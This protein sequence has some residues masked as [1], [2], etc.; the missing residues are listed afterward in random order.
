MKKIARALGILLLVAF[1]FS[2]CSKLFDEKKYNENTLADDYAKY[3]G[4]NGGS[5]S[6]SGGFGGG[7]GDNGGSSSINIEYTNEYDYTLEE[8]RAQ[9]EA[10]KEALKKLNYK[11][12]TYF[13]P[14]PTPPDEKQE[15]IIINEK[16]QQVFWKDD[17][18]IGGGIIYYYSPDKSRI[19]LGTSAANLFSACKKFYEIDMSG[20]DTRDVTTMES[21]FSFCESLLRVNMSSFNTSKVEKMTGMFYGCNRI[22]E[23]DFSSFNT[24]AVTS[25]SSMFMYCHSL[26]GLDLSNFNTSNVIYMDSMFESCKDHDFKELDLS[27][28]DT[29]KVISMEDMFSNCI[30]LEKLNISSFDFS[31]N[32]N[33]KNMFDKDER[34][35]TIYCAKDTDCTTLSAEFTDCFKGCTRLKGGWGTAFDEN[36]KDKEYARIDGGTDSPGY[37]TA[38]GEVAVYYNITSAETTEGSV[39]ANKTRAVSGDKIKLK[40]N[41][42][43]EKYVIKTIS[44]K[45]GEEDVELTAD[46]PDLEYSFIMPQGNVTISVTFEISY[47]T[48][49][50]DSLGGTPVNPMTIEKGTIP[51]KPTSPKLDKTEIDAAGIEYKYTFDGWYTNYDGENFSGHYSFNQ[52]LTTDTALYAKWSKNRIYKIE[53][54]FD[55]DKGTVSVEDSDESYYKKLLTIT[56]NE[57]IEIESVTF[58]DKNTNESIKEYVRIDSNKYR[59]YQ[60]QKDVVITVSFVEFTYAGNK[61][62]GVDEMDAFDIVFSDGS[63]MSVDE[64]SIDSVIAGLT[65]KQKEKAI[66]IIFYKGT[67]LNSDGDTTTVRTLG[68]GLNYGD[69]LYWNKNSLNYTVNIKSIECQSVSGGFSG[70]LNGKDN[71]EQMSEYLKTNGADHPNHPK[72][73]TGI[74]DNYTAW[75]WAKEYGSKF[76]N[77]NWSAYKDG[78]YV[79]SIAELSVLDVIG[80]QGIQKL[81]KALTGRYNSM[82][83]SSFVHIFSSSQ[84][85]TMNYW[86]SP[87]KEIKNFNGLAWCIIDGECQEYLKISKGRVIPIREF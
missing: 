42:K 72:D 12:M 18:I 24:S 23:I 11:E 45:C 70:D 17:S 21:M 32:K 49:T 80:E 31:K 65:E 40:V 73:D 15:T 28:F 71:F 74:K 4:G 37:F 81:E 9:S 46:V 52:K 25:M 3:G 87:S 13:K 51:E 41:P 83:K 64:I 69:D 33:F 86:E 5:G 43:E 82:L 77:L 85:P 20:F 8:L 6:G 1:S 29:S 59:F 26:R 27:N 79:P 54:S 2:S 84:H 30:N 68:V 47:I 35:E 19:T 50:F 53:T 66:A 48:I 22:T 75:Y 39:T 56:P 7:S 36:H 55:A 67:E 60:G 61:M 14:S 76:D 63:F 44:A 78:W 62:I 38:I 34:L 10:I 57:G 58:I 16:H